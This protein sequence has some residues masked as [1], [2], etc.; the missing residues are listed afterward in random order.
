MGEKTVKIPQKTRGS[1]TVNSKEGSKAGVPK[2]RRVLLWVVS[3]SFLIFL[4]VPGVTM[5]RE[6][7]INFSGYQWRLK[8]SPHVKIGPGPNFWSQSP[9]H[10]YVDERGRLHLEIS[11]AGFRWF[12]TEVKLAE[13]LGYGRYCLEIASLDRPLNKN[14]ILGFFVYLN[15]RQEIDIELGSWGGT[16]KQGTFAVQ[17]CHGSGDLRRYPVKLTDAPSRL[18]FTWL[19]D[20]VEFL[21]RKKKSEDGEGFKEEVAEW[22]Y[23]GSSVPE[24]PLRARINFWLYE[25]KYPDESKPLEVVVEE[26]SFTP[27]KRLEE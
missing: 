3:V 25:G 22:T 17:P 4:A 21:H 7:T 19:P 15:N 24:G 13:A 6:R 26:F 16:K 18:C 10:V 23:R 2:L 14:A 9:K 27:R 5:A 12:S 1:K 8:N 20:R 11:P